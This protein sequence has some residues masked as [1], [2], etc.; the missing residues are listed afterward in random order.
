MDEKQEVIRPAIIWS[1]QRSKSQ[2]DFINQVI[3]SRSLSNNM[4]N[5]AST[6]FALPSLLWIKENEPGNYEN[7]QRILLPKDYIRYGASGSSCY[8]RRHLFVKGLFATDRV[9][10]INC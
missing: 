10:G 1:D 8:G 6:G 2:V 9:P 5:C 3:R 7:T 4:L